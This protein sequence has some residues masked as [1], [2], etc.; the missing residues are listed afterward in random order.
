MGDGDEDDEDEEAE[1]QSGDEVTEVLDPNTPT[2]QN[3]PSTVVTK[4]RRIEKRA[5]KARSET[6]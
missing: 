4:R 5:Q 6:T 3:L 1:A 2:R